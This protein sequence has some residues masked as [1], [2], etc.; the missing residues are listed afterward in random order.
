MSK[1]PTQERNPLSSHGL[2]FQTS[3]LPQTPLPPLREVINK[4]GLGAKKQLGQNFLLDMNLTKKI[5]KAAGN[6]ADY[7]IIEI[8]PGP[9]G[10]TRALLSEGAKKIIALERDERF[11]SPLKEITKAYPEKIEIIHADALKFD[12]DSLKKEPIKIIANLPYN[13]ATPLLIKWLTKSSRPPFYDSLT[14]M[15][16]KEVAQRICAKQGDKNYGRLS[17]ISSFLTDAKILFDI[18]KSAFTPPP[19]VTSSLVQLVPKK[20]DEE[21]NIKLLEKITKAA[22]GQRRKMIRQSLKNLAVPIEPLL[23]AAHLKGTER[24]QDLP[25]STYIKLAKLLENSSGK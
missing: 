7:T 12:Y 3:S 20:I 6:L 10:L 4:Y 18:D 25:V 19:K 24:A 14:L 9:G 23:S 2:S 15:F 5:A 16:Q 22:F 8:G 13:I 11:L 17:I 1:S 21:V